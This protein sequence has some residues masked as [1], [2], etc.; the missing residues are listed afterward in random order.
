[1]NDQMNKIISKVSAVTSAARNQTRQMQSEPR[2]ASSSRGAETQNF[3]SPQSSSSRLQRIRNRTPNNNFTRLGNF[4]SNSTRV[5]YDPS[6]PT[7]QS[8]LSQMYSVAGNDRNKWS[9]LYNMFQRETQISTSPIY[10]PY[11]F[12]APAPNPEYA[13][14]NEA[15]TQKFETQW[16]DAKA[17]AAYWAGRTD[18]NLS[19]D[20]IIARVNLD[21]YSAIKALNKKIS[22]GSTVYYT[23]SLGYSPDVLY[24][25]IW[26]ARNGGST[27]NDLV[28]LMNYARGEGKGYE[29]NED[30]QARL[31]PT[32]ERY[33]PYSVG[34]TAD[35]IASYFGVAQFD[36]DWLAKNRYLLNGDDNDVERYQQVYDAEQTTQKAEAEYAELQKRMDSWFNTNVDDPNIILENLFGKDDV[37]GTEAL[38]T[39]GKMDE[40][41][42][43]GK[44]MSMTRPVDYSYAEVVR[45]VQE[46][47]DEVRA[48]KKTAA[49]AD[50]I[51]MYTGAGNTATAADTSIDTARDNALLAS[52]RTIRAM[53]TGEEKLVFS[54]SRS[55]FERYMQQVRDAVSDGKGMSAEQVYE[56]LLNGANQ[57]AAQNYLAAREAFGNLSLDQMDEFSQKYGVAGLLTSDAQVSA[58]AQLDSIRDSYILAAKLNDGKGADTSMLH[59]MDYLY[60]NGREYTPTEWSATTAF[61]MLI[62]SGSYT[63]EQVAE[64]ARETISQKQ[65]KIDEID[66]VL[67]QVQNAGIK[68]ADKYVSNLERMRDAY[69]QDVDDAKYFLIPEEAEDFKQVVNKYKFDAKEAWKGFDL[70]AGFKSEKNGIPQFDYQLVTLVNEKTGRRGIHDNSQDRYVNFLTDDEIDTYLYL[71]A[72]QGY[73][74]AQEYYNHLKEETLPVRAAIAVSENTADIASSGLLGA[75]AMSAMSVLASPAQVAG[76]AYSAI[77]GIRG[78]EINPYH[79]SFAANMFISSARGTVKNEISET[80]GEDT[81]WAKFAN[82]TYDALMS[83]GDSLLSGAIGSGIA[84][85][86]GGIASKIPGGGKVAAYMARKGASV[87]SIQF[88]SAEAAGGAVMDAKMRGATDTQALLMG[89]ISWVAESLTEYIPM[90]NIFNAF[91]GG[92]AEAARGLVSRVIRSAFE[93]APGEMASEIIEGLA[94]D[95]IMREMSERNLSVQEYI[96]NGMDAE[97]AERKATADFVKNVLY[98]GATGA[99]SGVMS[100]GTAWLGGKL[101]GNNT[102]TETQVETLQNAEQRTAEV[103]TVPEAQTVQTSTQNAAGSEI[104]A[105]ATENINKGFESVYSQLAALS[106][107]QQTQDKATQASVISGVFE[108]YGVDAETAR[109]AGQMLVDRINGNRLIGAMEK[110]LYSSIEQGINASDAM[111]AVAYSGLSDGYAGTNQILEISAQP[112]E[113]ISSDVLNSFIQSNLA[114]AEGTMQ[115]MQKRVTDNAIANAMREIVADGGLDGIRTYETALQQA[116]QNVR[117]ANEGLARVTAERD[118]AGQNLQDIQAKFVENPADPQMAGAMQQAIRDMEGKAKVVAEYQQ[119]VAKFENQRQ[120]AETTLNNARETAMKQVRQE[121]VQRVMEQRAALAEEAA[122][123]DAQVQQL[124]EEAVAANAQVQESARAGYQK[125]AFIP[126]DGPV[127]QQVQNTQRETTVIDDANFAQAQQILSDAQQEAESPSGVRS[128]VKA[129]YRALFGERFNQKQVT[130]DNVQFDGQPYMVTIFKNLI[131]KV[132]SD[133]N[134]SAEKMA[135]LGQIEQVVEKSNYD[136]SSGVDRTTQNKDNVVRYDYL[137]SDASINDTNYELRFVVEVYEK[138]NKLKTYLLKDMEMTP[139]SLPATGSVPA[140]TG[141]TTLPPTGSVPAAQSGESFDVNSVAQNAASVNPSISNSTQNYSYGTQDGMQESFSSTRVAPGNANGPIKSGNQIMQEIAQGLGLPSDTRKSDYERSL[142][143]GTKGYTRKGYGSIHVLDAQNIKTA[144][145]EWGH[146]FDQAFDLQNNAHIQEM[147]KTLS[148]DPARG[149]WLNSYDDA[150]KPGEV[151]A[152]YVKYWMMDRDNAIAFAGKDFTNYFEK[153]LK[154][155]GWLK[156]MQQGALDMRNNLTT[157]AANRAMAEIALEEPK[158]KNKYEK[159][160]KGLAFKYLDFTL[161]WQEVTETMKAAGKFKADTDVRTL[162]LAKESMVKN[163]VDSCL[164][165]HLVDPRGN[166]VDEK[167][168]KSILNKVPQKDEKAFNT[169]W[170]LLHAQ[171]RQDMTIAK[172]VFGEDVNID[173]AIAQLEAEHPDFHEII[174]QAEEWYTKFMQTWEVDTGLLD[175]DAF[176]FMR[177]TYPYYVPLF[178]TGTGNAA[179][180]RPT[181]GRRNTPG[182]G[183]K[184]AKGSTADKYNP[185]MGIVEYMQHYIANYKNIE[186]LRAFDTTMKAYPGLNVI[187]EPVQGDMT[188]ESYTSANARAKQAVQEALEALRQGGENVTPQVEDTL[189]STMDALPSQGW[190]AK[191]T[192]TGED[193]LNIPLED[194]TISRWVVHN[195]PMMQALL[196]L[197][198]SR[199]NNLLQAVGNLTRFLSAQATSRSATFT[200][201]NLLSD[202]QTAM[203]TGH[204]AHTPI[205]YTANAI[206]SAFD[207]LKNNI[208]D[209]RGKNVSETYRLF[210]IFGKMDSRYALRDKRTQT[211]IR[212]NLYGKSKTAADVAKKIVSAPIIGLEALSEFSEN[213]SRYNAFR[214]DGVEKTTYAGALES[215]RHAREDTTDFSKHGLNTE[216]LKFAKTVVPFFNAS[217]QGVYKTATLFKSENAGNRMKIAGGLVAGVLLPRMVIEAIKGMTWNDEEKEA[218]KY[219]NQYEKDSYIHLKLPSGR[220]IK[221]KKSQDAIIKITDAVG[222]FLYDVLTGYETNDEDPV[223]SAMAE[224][225]AS[226]FEIAKNSVVQFDTVFNPFIDAANNRTW[227]GAEIEN[228]Q[229]LQLPTTQRYDEDTLKFFHALSNASVA[230]GIDYSPKDWEYIFGQYTGSMGAI[231][232]SALELAEKGEFNMGN[233]FGLITDKISSRMSVDPVYS[234]NISSTFYGYKTLLTENLA[235]IDAKRN[236]V[237]LRRSLT[238]EEI[239]TAYAEGTLLLKK[240]GAIGAA[241]EK[242]KELWKEIDEIMD[243][244][245]MTDAEKESKAREV[246]K[247]INQTLLEANAAYG[248]YMNKYGYDNGAKKALDNMLELFSPK[249]PQAEDQVAW[250]AMSDTFKADE[251]KS[252]MQKSRAVWEATGKDSAL[253]HPN[254]SFDEQKTTYEIGA[255]DWDGWET[256]YRDAYEN[257]VARNASKWDGMTDEEK[258]GVLTK[259]HSEGHNAAKAWYWQTHEKPKQTDK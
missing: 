110:M 81:G 23:R 44:I 172:A 32:N 217:L 137:I 145:H 167:S 106:T 29:R 233:L 91:K 234:N 187:A 218:E 132:V 80:L 99:L 51:S 63:R 196:A 216:D 61:Q 136:S 97:E 79:G 198:Q 43:S 57:Y 189:L 52:G 215:G 241:T 66:G 134:L 65:A 138:H 201:Q 202:S 250:Y 214:K 59:L 213:I 180:N 46:H 209:A 83:S 38:S 182:S 87:A 54:T 73:D 178:R 185:A 148:S 100:T 144:A 243:S 64:G 227:S 222:K 1:M 85:S 139:A 16:A 109:A 60:D 170:A 155:K 122:L 117:T 152:E 41:L 249:K 21:G 25:V 82:M 116:E 124:A 75:A 179:E 76:T 119:S 223:V 113:S 35:D 130:V 20:D 8:T 94:D 28:D 14:K 19:D 219:L 56:A 258:L 30:I 194:G 18:L 210:K 192:A 115:Q 150:Q 176:N 39:L 78:E 33:N 103:Q 6:N 121:A 230:L 159:G 188:R 17:K 12:N 88:M 128:L 77:Q 108:S 239:N 10:S 22:E 104:V 48:Q 245:T 161:P 72:T 231:G 240:E 2:A 175:Q 74:K 169:L 96:A 15:D 195:Q 13:A 190:V 105:N 206:S 135:V 224:L 235:A 90:D 254:T 237:D 207:L 183:V 131:N 156:T 226:A 244:E 163:L 199:R 84:G 212:K 3:E 37:N 142:R 252:Y 204:T 24:G 114:N 257:Y 173:A 171:A 42:K 120:V 69:Q 181:A 191:D 102:Q 101:A 50:E 238:Q 162:L 174:D 186:T 154:K 164:Y 221:F 89:G 47:C 211:E 70:F 133:P 40:S 251:N 123:R 126:Y 168:F 248:D 225:K 34:S 27:G 127:P 107:A 93:E 53:G 9:T 11:L 255:E 112:T 228:Y 184:R 253:P 205:R 86:L 220:M 165:D 45:Q 5:R 92:S 143:K 247:Q 26:A 160:M 31:D 146:V 71:S 157:T 197:P 140:H 98:A 141:T 118:A 158:S 147:V 236:P 259:A 62:D 232:V 7:L 166:I 149:A 229:M 55:G 200:V 4:S 256:A 208:L 111:K 58:R 68:G 36:S 203:V 177:A 151:I 67:E 95:L 246:R 125:K 242:A 193:V 153:S 49:V 129:A